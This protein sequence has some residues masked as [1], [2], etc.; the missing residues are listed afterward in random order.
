MNEY[1]VGKLVLYPQGKT[2]DGRI[3]RISPAGIYIVDRESDLLP[4]QPVEK[5]E[6]STIEDLEFVIPQDMKNLWLGCGGV[7][8]QLGVVLEYSGYFFCETGV[9]TLI[10][11]QIKKF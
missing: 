4:H 5:H 10:A 6:Q 11:S 7:V 8:D 1:M 9:P 3:F 2:I